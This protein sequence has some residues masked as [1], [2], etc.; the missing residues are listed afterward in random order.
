MRRLT[1]ARPRPWPLALVVI[2]GVKIL[3]WIS[4]GMPTPVSATVM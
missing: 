2:M 1:T 3:F 4:L